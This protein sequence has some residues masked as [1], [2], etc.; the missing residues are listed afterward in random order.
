MSSRAV[1]LLSGGLDSCVAA[2]IAS[3][4]RDVVGL[5]VAY[6]QRHA[7]E[8][9]AAKTIADRL[10]IAL[11]LA[12][13]DVSALVGSA[14]LGSC[15]VSKGRSREEIV[16]DAAPT[17]FVPARNALFLTLA[18]AFATSIGAGEVWVGSNADDRNGYPDCRAEFFDA[19][20]TVSALGGFGVKIVRPLIDLSKREV[21]R[22]GRKIE[23]PIDLSWSCYSP[24]GEEG[25]ERPCWQCDA[26]VL[27]VEALR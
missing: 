10:G 13:A 16:T 8:L 1:V 14:L 5:A 25:N 2:T 17:T 4:T 23:A 6:G 7:C 15:A 3:A 22:L 9:D 26:C 20:E 21:A 12:R 24:V 18:S 27:R 19:F 11:H